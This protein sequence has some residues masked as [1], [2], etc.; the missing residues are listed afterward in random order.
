MTP[1]EEKASCIGG[2]VIVNMSTLCRVTS[3][4]NAN[5]IKILATKD[6]PKIIKQKQ[7]KTLNIQSKL[8]QKSKVRSIIKVVLKYA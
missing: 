8:E 7:K 3:R 1:K 4:F 2:I 5:H 6:N